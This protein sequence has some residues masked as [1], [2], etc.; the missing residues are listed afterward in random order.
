MVALSTVK[1]SIPLSEILL[2]NTNSLLI[3]GFG[4]LGSRLARLL[5]SDTWDISACRRHPDPGAQISQFAAD[6][7]VPGSLQFAESLQPDF[8]VATFTPGTRDISGYQRGFTDA[9]Y[10]LLQGLG[11]HRPKRLI[12]VS[13][14]R[15][16]A[17]KEGGWV[18]ESSELSTMDE[19]AVAIAEAERCL[20]ASQHEATVV[21]FGGIYGGEG[22]RLMARIARGEIAPAEPVRYTN[23]IHRDDCVGFLAHLMQMAGEGD[24]V[25]PV[26]NGVD[27]D[28]AAAHEVESWLAARMGCVPDVAAKSGATGHKRCIN[29][30]LNATG[31]KL[32]FP[33]YKAGYLPILKGSHNDQQ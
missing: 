17:E 16:Y 8:V 9:A 11:E 14:T 13:S 2:A 25:L 19:R 26:Y 23:R 1:A 30:L 6:Y 20:L 12:M 32:Q 27:N 15:V 21:R 22:S 28:P 4:D 31:Y 18:D 3:V 7:T 33:D 10:N 24:E 5:Y 29:K